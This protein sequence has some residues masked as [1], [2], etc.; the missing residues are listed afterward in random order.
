MLE[1]HHNNIRF[2]KACG[3]EELLVLSL[4]VFCKFRTTFQKNY[5][6]FSFVAWKFPSLKEEIYSYFGSKS[7]V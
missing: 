5:L 4:Q 3:I 7:T 1:M 6:K 2:N